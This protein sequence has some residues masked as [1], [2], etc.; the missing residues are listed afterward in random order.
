MLNTVVQILLGIL[1]GLY[2]AFLAPASQRQ[3]AHESIKQYAAVPTVQEKPMLS[4]IE[5]S[6]A[7][8]TAQPA[9]APD[10]L[11]DPWLAEFAPSAT[12]TKENPA[13][14]ATHPNPTKL[15]YPDQLDFQQNVKANQRKKTKPTTDKRAVARTQAPVVVTACL[16]KMTVEQLRSLCIERNIHWRNAHGSRHLTKTEM[17]ERLTA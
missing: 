4:Q 7:E 10:T 2:L 9:V 16:T 15:L 17:L 1:Y 11:E 6:V 14:S 8:P 5:T 12:E 3:K 13:A